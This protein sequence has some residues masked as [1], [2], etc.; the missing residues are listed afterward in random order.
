MMTLN[1]IR[2]LS[3]CDTKWFG[4]TSIAVALLNRCF[5]IQ[6]T[7]ENF[8]E[9]EILEWLASNCTGLF[10]ADDGF[11]GDYAEDTY[12]VAFSNDTDMI[13]FKMRFEG[14]GC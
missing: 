3:N 1:K 6:P 5:V 12:T 2:H 11:M 10:Y 13:A 7:P 8:S 14:E 9:E 4:G